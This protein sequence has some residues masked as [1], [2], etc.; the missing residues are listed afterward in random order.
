MLASW[1]RE[2]LERTAKI[3][4]LPY[5]WREAESSGVPALYVHGIPTASWDWIPFLERTGGIAPDLPGFGRSAKRG[6]LPFDIPGYA[7]F[8]ERF[9]DELEI[10]RVKLVAHDW[11]AVA[12]A[13]AQAQPQRIERLVLIDA[14]PL[15]PGFHWRG[16]ARAWCTPVLGEACLGLVGRLSLRWVTRAANASPGPLPAEMRARILADFDPGTERAILRL[17]RSSPPQVLAAAGARLSLLEVPALVAWGESDPYIPHRFADA[18]AAMLPD[19]RLLKLHDAGHWPWLD[20][21]ELVDRVAEFLA[22]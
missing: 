1:M 2:V 5:L 11:G 3:D 15:L 22:A 8:L 6:D 13:F 19:A 17:H 21:P 4:E 7:R 12:L 18:Y 10:E 14:V 9:L 16:L 20:R